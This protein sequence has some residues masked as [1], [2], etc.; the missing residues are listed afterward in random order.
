MAQNSITVMGWVAPC[1]GVSYPVWIFS[2]PGTVPMVDTVISTDANC[3]Y[4]FTFHP[5]TSAGGIAVVTSCDGGLTWGVEDSSAYNTAGVDTLVMNLSC[6][7]TITDCLGISGGTNLPGTAC[8]DGNPVTTGDTWSANCI[9]VGTVCEAPV[10][11]SLPQTLTICSSDSLVLQ[12]ITNGSGP[13]S[14]SWTGPGT[15]I[16]NNTS[17]TVYFHDF[18]SGTYHVTVAN[19]CGTAEADVIVTITQAPDAGIS[20]DT[21]LCDLTTAV[22]LFS[23]IGG[24][25]DAGGF[26]SGGLVGG[27]Y[28]PTVNPPGSYTYTSVGTAPCSN[29][30]ATVT[31]TG[32][33]TWYG[34]ADGD[35]LGDNYVAVQSC[36]QPAGYVSNAFDHCPSV[37]GSSG[38][39]CDDGD[40]LTINDHLDFNCECVGTDPTFVDCLGIVGGSNVVGTLCIDT[41]GGLAHMGTW[42]E[43]CNCPPGTWFDCLSIWHGPN[44]PGSACTDSSGVPGTWSPSCVCLG[45]NCQ[46]CITTTQV[47][48]FTALFTSCSTGGTLPFDVSWDFPPGG[49]DGD[50]IIQV[51]PGPGT[52]FACLNIIDANGNWCGTCDSVFVG[53]D[54]T[55]NP[56]SPQPCTSSFWVIQAYDSTATGVEPIPNEVWVWNLSSGGNGNYQFLW[57]FG[58]GTTSTDAYPTHV[59]TG[60]GPWNLCLTIASGLCTDVYCDSVSVDANGILNQLVIG[61]GNGN[62]HE[63]AT[64]TRSGGFTLNVIQ[65]I[66]T[67]IAEIPAF[68]ELKAWPNPALNELS[69]SF[70]TRVSGT[71]PVTVIDPSGR[72]VISESQNL[73]TG[74][75]TFRISTS[76]LEPGLYM[77]RIGNDARSI[78]QRFMKVR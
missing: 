68:A 39:A 4:S 1:S 27:M 31:I 61:G 63:A 54:G 64:G 67:A 77:V 37:F 9:C 33:I 25:P 56:T 72:T 28:D 10:I 75:N 55:I 7:G 14:Y 60:D 66:P 22:S 41:I 57:N 65:Q 69:L 71:V 3:N 40:P 46:A 38:S 2:D 44:L 73:T 34:D 62:V 26:W 15:F 6:G 70:N 24:T 29:A 5:T 47:A 17:Q 59:Y 30:T 74:S 76:T 12:A 58:D 45:P 18:T 35:G 20:V 8:D 50:S 23:I 43:N 21:S 42:D 49:L 78:T 11:T 51:Y 19:D 36:T 53:I 32:S 13:M 52:Y 16:P 48:P